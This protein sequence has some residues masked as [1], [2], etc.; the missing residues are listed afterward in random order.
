M[1]LHLCHKED[2]SNY[3][4][5]FC[6]PKIVVTPRSQKLRR[7]PNENPDLICHDAHTPKHESL[8]T[9]LWETRVFWKLYLPPNDCHL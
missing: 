9:V 1:L 8:T 7:G 3:L 6:R 5:W 4:Y 2:T